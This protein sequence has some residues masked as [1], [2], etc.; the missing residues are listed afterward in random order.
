MQRII[1]QGGSSIDKVLGDLYEDIHWISLISGNILT[2][3]NAQSI[4]V[5]NLLVIQND[6]L[7]V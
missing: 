3:V 1:S 4:I 2:L 7:D 5:C 6:W